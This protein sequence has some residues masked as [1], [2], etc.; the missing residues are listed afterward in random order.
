MQDFQREFRPC[1]RL[2]GHGAILGWDGWNGKCGMDGPVRR[3]ASINFNESRSIEI[4]PSVLTDKSFTFSLSM[5]EGGE[6]G[7]GS[8]RCDRTR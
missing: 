8:G 2:F 1:R 3:N 4:D 5:T 7:E 6:D